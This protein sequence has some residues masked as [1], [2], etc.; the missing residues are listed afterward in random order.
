VLIEVKGVTLEIDNITMF[1]DVP[2][3]R[4]VKHIFE[5]CDS[6]KE[7]YRSF[8]V[9]VIQMSGVRYFTPNAATHQTFADAL[10]HAR[11]QGVF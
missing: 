3:E 7:G 6:L 1:P 4:G 9:F 2:A 10:I 11:K 5:H 8:V